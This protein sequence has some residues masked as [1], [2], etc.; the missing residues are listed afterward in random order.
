MGSI[1]LLINPFVPFFIGFLLL[2]FIGF[3]LFIKKPS[4]FIYVLVFFLP[5]TLLVRW[6]Q[7]E[8]ILP[9]GFRTE[10]LFFIFILFLFNQILSRKVIKYNIGSDDIIIVVIVLFTIMISFIRWTGLM[11]FIMMLREY[12][13]ILFLYPIFK[14]H[15]LNKNIKP[16]SILKYFYFGLILVAIFNILFYYKILTFPFGTIVYQ[17]NMEVVTR[18]LF[19]IQIERMRPILGVS[20][21]G[22]AILFFNNALLGIYWYISE[23]IFYKKIIYVAGISVLLWAS[24]L[25][26]S[27]S[28]FIVLFSMLLSFFLFSGSKRMLFFGTIIV[29]F[30]LIYIGPLIKMEIEIGEYRLYEY[31]GNLFRSYIQNIFQDKEISELLTG[32]GFDI[33]SSFEL[34]SKDFVKRDYGIFSVFISHG[35]PGLLLLVSLYTTYFYRMSKINISLRSTKWLIIF[36]STSLISSFFFLHGSPLTTRPIDIF[37]IINASVITYYYYET[38]KEASHS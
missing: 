33:K 30:V 37:I 10:Y 27:F 11:D 13:I 29:L 1:I 15:L 22:A 20:A 26:I 4:N 3:I 6:S 25:L 18:A 35:L 7:P 31:A 16:N 9:A 21:G 8:G 36:C 17:T 38:K 34:A 12:V 14:Y 5:S 19:G 24:A 23:R 28:T 2:I 32:V